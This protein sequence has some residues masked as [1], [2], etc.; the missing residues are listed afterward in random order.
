[1][2]LVRH[3]GWYVPSVQF[4]LCENLVLGMGLTCCA[5]VLSENLVF[6]MGLT[7]CARVLSAVHARKHDRCWHC[8]CVVAARLA[9]PFRKVATATRST[10]TQHG[11]RNSIAVVWA[12]F[13]RVGG[14]VL[15]QGLFQ[16][17]QNKLPGNFGVI[18]L[19]QDCADKHRGKRTMQRR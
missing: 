12:K 13:Y 4:L 3:L 8:C 10:A 15:H 16:K 6:G 18:T 11:M 19:F 9:V 2:S 14:Y 1:M 7:C 17:R 5:R